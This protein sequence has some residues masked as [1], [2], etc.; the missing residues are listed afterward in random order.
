MAAALPYLLGAA[1][2]ATL[3]VLFAGVISFAMNGN[4]N[5]KY[6]TKLMAA[7]V[8]LQG[9]AIVLFAATVLF[10]VR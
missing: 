1:M 7:R 9:V 2:L 4:A 5:R 8:I 3:G 6:A 10:T